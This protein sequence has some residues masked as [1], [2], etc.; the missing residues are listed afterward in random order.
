MNIDEISREVSRK[1]LTSYLHVKRSHMIWL[2]INSA[3]CSEGEII[4]HS[5][6][7]YIINKTI[8]GQLRDC[9]KHR[10]YR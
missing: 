10:L 4:W 3:F 7:V 2:Q 6:S 9:F 1:N 5:I 8:H